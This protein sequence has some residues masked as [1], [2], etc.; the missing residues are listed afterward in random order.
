MNTSTAEK[1]L[2]LILDPKNR[3]VLIAVSLAEATAVQVS[4]QTK[5]PVTEVRAALAALDQLGLIK[6]KAKGKPILYRVNKAFVDDLMSKK[7]L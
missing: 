7:V 4:E 5:L 6:R 2:Q 1:I 3:A